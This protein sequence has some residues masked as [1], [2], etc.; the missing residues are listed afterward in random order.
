MENKIRK[1][2]VIAMYL[3]QY[4]PIPENDKT[5]GKGF[6]EWTNVVQARPLF[7]DHYQP[8]IP[9]DLGFYDLRLSEVREAQAEMAR[10]AGV[11]GFMYWHYW[12][13]NGK[14]LLEKPFQEVLNSGKPD[15]PFSLGWANH[16]WSTKTWTKGKTLSKD[17]MIME[18]LYPGEDDY[19]AH[20]K[21]VLP[22]LK[23]KRY[24][25]VDG[26]PIFVVYDPY[27]IPQVGEFIKLWKKMALDNGLS[28]IH[29]V[30]LKAGRTSSTQELLDMGF[31]AVNNRNMWEAEAA[32]IGSRLKRRLNSLLT[33]KLGI[34]LTKYDYKDVMKNLC[35][36]EDRLENVYP[37]ILPGY[38]RTAR[39]G[40]R[41]I[42]YDNAT[43][44]YFGEHVDDVLGYLENKDFEHK[45]VFLKSWNEWGE[46]NYMEPDLKYGHDFLNE[47]SK[48]ILGQ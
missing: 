9:A 37:T 1:A 42:I 15:F 30:G 17:S 2:R 12:F 10:E 32:S 48:R 13:G 6:T 19:I 5:W 40:A 24:I 43:P 33:W 7:K 44:K 20:F 29:F 4:H 36:E 27:S 16:S 41:A 34:K 21:Y 25:T 35:T 47:L 22:A 26:K 8:R 28:G 38:D 14:M 11:E 23:D 45:I 3:P 39:A 18:Q 31:D 46:G